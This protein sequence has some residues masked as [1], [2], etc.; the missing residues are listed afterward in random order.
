MEIRV[1]SLSRLISQMQKK[2]SNGIWD[3]G[4]LGTQNTIAAHVHT[5]YLYDFSEFR[6]ITHF[7]FKE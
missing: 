1:R 5:F 6:W 2:G 4:T 7:Y 3:S